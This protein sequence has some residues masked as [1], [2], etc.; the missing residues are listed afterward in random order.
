MFKKLILLL[1]F[2]A[3]TFASAQT[4]TFVELTSSD[5]RGTFVGPSAVHIIQG[6]DTSRFQYGDYQTSVSSFTMTDEGELT[7]PQGVFTSVG[8][9]EQNYRNIW[10]GLGTN[11]RFYNPETEVEL[12]NIRLSSY[13][14]E[15]VYGGLTNPD[16]GWIRGEG[17]LASGF[18]RI[19]CEYT[20]VSAEL[21]GLGFTLTGVSSDTLITLDYPAD[22]RGPAGPRSSSTVIFSV[23]RDFPELGARGHYFPTAQHVIDAVNIFLEEVGCTSCITTTSMGG[24]INA[25]IIAAEPNY[26][27]QG[28]GIWI[29][30]GLRPNGFAEPT[31]NQIEID[32]SQFILEVGAGGDGLVGVRTS[33]DCLEELLDN[34]PQ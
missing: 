26:E 16:S 10:I 2:S 29:D 22:V 21:P 24:D 30:R 28:N 15:N 11:G 14:V 8:N 3:T 34:L 33:Y 23:S 17:D 31:W 13:L 18:Y 4:I 7:I 12:E 1:I 32:G 20:F 5:G 9:F 25:A 27:A 6:D 19:A